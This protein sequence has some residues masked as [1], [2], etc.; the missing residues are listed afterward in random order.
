MLPWLSRLPTPL[1]HAWLPSDLYDKHQPTWPASEID[2]RYRM[3][4]SGQLARNQCPP[5]EKVSHTLGSLKL[6][7]F[8]S[9]GDT[10]SILEARGTALWTA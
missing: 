9:R 6:V 1:A 5:R 2:P 7:G 3:I 10:I 8:R 4:Y